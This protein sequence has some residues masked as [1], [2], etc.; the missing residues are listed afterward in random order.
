MEQCRKLLV[1][2]KKSTIFT[3]LQEWSVIFKHV[4]LNLLLAF[5]AFFSACNCISQIVNKTWDAYITDAEREK[6]H[7]F[8]LEFW[9][10]LFIEF[11]TYSTILRL[12]TFKTIYHNLSLSIIPNRATLD[13][14]IIHKPT[15]AYQKLTILL[16][17]YLYIN[18]L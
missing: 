4:Y 10:H 11:Y 6:M 7:T 8:G 9:H 13:M 15:T 18:A 17:K 2:E 14:K 1:F 5:W 16:C 12:N 3:T